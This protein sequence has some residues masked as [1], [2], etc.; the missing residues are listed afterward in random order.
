MA[1]LLI[2]GELP[3]TD[4]LEQFTDSITRHSLIHEEMRRFF[5]SF[6]KNAHPMAVAAMARQFQPRYAPVAR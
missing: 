4:Q 2:Y 6:P 5:D 3:T 1:Y